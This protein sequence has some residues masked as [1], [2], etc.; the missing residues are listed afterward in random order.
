[1]TTASASLPFSSNFSKT[2]F[3]IFLLSVTFLFVE[4]VWFLPLVRNLG[5]EKISMHIT[6]I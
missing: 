2:S 5:S 3:L 6:K 1:M 4:L